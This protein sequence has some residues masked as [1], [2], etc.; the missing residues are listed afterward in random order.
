MAWS[1]PIDAYCERTDATFWAEPVNALTNG[2][3][4]IAA[5]VLALAA[6]RRGGDLPVLLLAGLIAVIGVG[7]FLFHTVATRWAALADV[8]P[9]AIFI[10][11][12]FFL[13]LTR[14]LR[15]TIPVAAAL[16]LAFLAASYP[17]A[18][19]LAPLL[20]GSSGYAPALLALVGVGLAALPRDRAAARGLLAGAALF[21]VSLAAR[22]ADE[23]LCA[24]WPLG[25]HGL[26]HGLNA[27]LLS[28]LGFVALR[29]RRLSPA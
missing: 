5:V 3:F 13:A 28:H 16:T 9:I 26:W 15:L 10:H 23:P 6:R 7:S 12:Y 29:A 27:V 21:A 8:I 18:G 17:L 11:A 14:I 20:G 22:M 25:T 1:D 24:A 19:L 4:L 2:A